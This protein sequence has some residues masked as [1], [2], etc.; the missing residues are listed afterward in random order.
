MWEKKG[1]KWRWKKV[2][3][4]R[5]EETNTQEE[6][7]WH[8]S[9]QKFRPD[10]NPAAWTALSHAQ[11]SGQ[12]DITVCFDLLLTYWP[13]S[14]ISLL[15]VAPSWAK[16]ASVMSLCGGQSN[17][18]LYF[19]KKTS[20]KNISPDNPMIFNKRGHLCDTIKSD[21]SNGDVLVKGHNWLVVPASVFCVISCH[22]L[23][24]GL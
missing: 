8:F 7:C 17:I 21:S 24:D 19:F 4:I 16:Q 12:W 18:S 22:V 2:K 9:W 5:S 6:G 14:Y 11:L 10:W 23:I 15:H 20:S 13:P 3:K 1:R